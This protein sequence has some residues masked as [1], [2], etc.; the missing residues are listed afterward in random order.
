MFLFL[1][2]TSFVSLSGQRD[3]SH[4]VYIF[5]WM[6][7]CV[8]GLEKAGLP[9]AGEDKKKIL[10]RGTFSAS[11]HFLRPST[12]I[13]YVSHDT[14]FMVVCC[15]KRTFAS[16]FFFSSWY[17]AVHQSFRIIQNGRPTAE[18]RLPNYKSGFVMFEVRF[19][20]IQMLK[21]SFFGKPS[22]YKSV[23]LSYA[24]KQKP[25]SEQES[26]STHY[27]YAVIS[28]FGMKNFDA[29]L[30]FFCS[31]DMFEWMCRTIPS[32]WQEA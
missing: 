5:I 1:P 23:N 24:R 14:V 8:W 30:M 32:V 2:H 21:N 25:N 18:M 22:F 11:I 19:F 10:S 3:L 20:V 29:D 15:T 12:S 17:I 31:T 9:V 26:I 27:W 4:I 13:I 6:H 28:S 16:C 7:F